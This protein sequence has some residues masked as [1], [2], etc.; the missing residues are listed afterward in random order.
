M[1]YR[2]GKFELDTEMFE[3]RQAG[4]GVHV[5]PLVFDLLR[6]LVENPGRVLSRSAIVDAV[7]DGR[8]ISDSTISGAI[9]SARKALREDAQLIKT[10]RGRG[11][12]FAGEV[13]SESG[14]H[15]AAHAITDQTGNPETQP[16]SP[17]RPSIAVLPLHVLT[18]DAGSLG[19]GDAVSQEVILELSRL[20]WMFVTA[21]GSS[22]Q[23]RDPSTDQATISAVLGVRY[24]LAGT[25]AIHG[26]QATVA[27]ELSI[28]QTGEVVWAEHFEMPLDQL[29]QLKS[30]IAANIV[31]VVETRIQAKEALEAARLP[32][33][34]LDAWSAYHRG[35]W[36]MYRFTQPDNE[37]AAR[38]FHRAI[39]VDPGFAR[40][41]AGLSFTH[42]QNAFLDYSVDRSGNRDLARRY[43]EKCL[44]LDPLDPFCNL[45]MGRSSWLEGDLF[46]A[47]PWLQRSIDLS[48]NYAFALY[49]RSLLSVLQGDGMEGEAGA[50]KALALSPIDPLG[51]AMLG[52]RAMSH[53][54]RGEYAEAAAWVD[55]AVAAPNAHVHIHVIAALGHALAGH[56]DRAAKCVA[57]IRR[58]N[59]DF[60]QADF[61]RAFP[62]QDARF[63]ATAKEA[64]DRH[65]L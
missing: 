61:F 31:S 12:Q 30:T 21:R 28:G 2:F 57:T 14:P 65:G 7:W 13:I 27:V 16:P 50:T 25:I 42:F 3:L 46:A 64:L 59:T 8:I 4:T 17:T 15:T 32:T 26:S 5:E 51:Y 35:L 19:L 41:Y 33:E 48:P 29:L 62:F 9:K 53:M 49:N 43:A 40:A 34:N 52:T 22:F 18:P 63:L 20:H 6:F 47:M 36:S 54:V 37:E 10:I 24:I 38:L 1:R 55:K 39:A 23:F 58:L 56:N 11:F 45:T 44:E 60:N